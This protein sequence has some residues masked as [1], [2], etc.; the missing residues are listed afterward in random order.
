MFSLPQGGDDPS[1][2]N[3]LHHPA[4]LER[5]MGE[6]GVTDGDVALDGEAHDDENGAVCAKLFLGASKSK[7]KNKVIENKQKKKK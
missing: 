4:Q 6:Q 3:H 1:E 2:G 7:K 5:R